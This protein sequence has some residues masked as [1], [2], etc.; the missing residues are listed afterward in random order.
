MP[1]FDDIGDSSAG[2]DVKLGCIALLKRSYGEHYGRS[3]ETSKM[4][5]GFESKS[6]ICAGYNYRLSGQNAGWNWWCDEK[7]GVEEAEGHCC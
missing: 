6:S 5:C 1:D 3:A 4:S 2:F 7:L